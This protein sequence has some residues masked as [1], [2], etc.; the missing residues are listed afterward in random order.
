MKKAP[1]PQPETE[2]QKPGQRDGRTSQREML[3]DPAQR[4]RQHQPAVQIA[5]SNVQQKPEKGKARKEAVENVLQKHD[6][7][8]EREHRT[9]DPEK[10]IEDREQNAEKERLPYGAARVCDPFPHGG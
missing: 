3:G 7:L 6:K 5:V 2:Y 1:Y 10:V 8:R 9:P 4:R